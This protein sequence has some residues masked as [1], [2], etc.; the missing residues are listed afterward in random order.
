MNNWKIL[1]ASKRVGGRVR[2]T[3]LNGTKPDDYQYQEMGPMRFPTRIKYAGTN[4]TLEIQDHKM[5]FQLGA[6][7]ND[8]NKNKSS[9]AVKFIPFIQNSANQPS[10]TSKRRPDGTVPGA[11][12]V[13]ANPALADNPNSTYSNATAVAI[14]KA[15]YMSWI[16]LDKG[17]TKAIASDVFRAHKQ[18]IKDGLFDY[19]ESMYLRY[20]LHTNLNITDQISSTA[21]YN[22]AWPYEWVYFSATTW[23]TIDKGLSQLPAAFMPLIQNKTRFGVSVSELRW[24]AARQK[25]SAHWRP[26]DSNP[27]SMKTS[28]EEFDYTIVAAPFTKVRLWRLPHY[29]SLLSRAINTLSY[30][31]ACKVALH[32]KSRFWEHLP[33]PIY[34]GCG[35]SDIPGI[36]SIC[37]PS[38]KINSSGPGV[39]LGSY[40]F[41]SQARTLGSMS[42]IDHVALVQRA[43]IETHGPIAASQYTGRYDR[44]CWDN[45]EFQAG[46][47]C[48]PM[49]GQEELYLPAYYQTEMHTVF[50]GEHTSF[51]HAWIFSA[52]ESAVRGV[53]QLLLDM[54][55][56]DEAKA[57]TE[58]WMARWLRM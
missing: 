31:Q 53:A 47:W 30:Q 20:A 52:L 48:A 11:A 34:G 1:E 14:G 18:A 24:N 42:T 54:G 6:A 17:R 58:T 15:E 38:Y 12:E 21:D 46:A 23:K 41:G 16:G 22:P 29:S 49:V 3:Y 55:L 28:S 43:M 9:L 2:T 35:S 5:V 57:V 13:L 50:V 27:F 51:T 19:S 39:L 56:V 10:G 33:N 26:T 44:T 37:Y 45:N 8:I 4:E 36:G 40:A 32:Y 7:L 25:I